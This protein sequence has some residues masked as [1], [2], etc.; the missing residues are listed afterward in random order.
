MSQPLLELRHASLGFGRRAV[1]NGAAMAVSQGAF[2]G[3]L[4]P[5]G[6]GKTTLL[7]TILGLLPP[8]RGQ[9]LAHG[10]DEG[11]PRFGYVPQKERLDPIYPLTAEEVVSMGTARRLR[12]FGGFG[13][14]RGHDRE[15]VHRSLKECGALELAHRRFSDL[16]GGQ[17]QR[18]LI[19]RAL[20]SE[21]ELLVLDEPL[22][23]IDVATQKA[24]LKLFRELKHAGRLTVLLVSHRL[25][26]E[27]SLFTEIAWVDEGKVEFGPADRLLNHKPLVEFFGHE[28]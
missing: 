3:I 15:L 17:K 27:R 9:L 23:G 5:N 28:P 6:A 7:R 20:A 10:G 13:R 4:G 11:R 16:S 22:A 1:V 18:V 21:P 24:L 26:A 2:V 12:L 19:A 25:Q 8:L 14:G